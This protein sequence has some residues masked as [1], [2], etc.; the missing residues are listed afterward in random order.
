MIQAIKDKLDYKE[1]REDIREFREN[2]TC[3]VPHGIAVI[4]GILGCQVGQVKPNLKQIHPQHFLNSHG[5][6]TT[7]PL[8][9]AGLDNIYPFIP[10]NDLV[11]DFQKFLSL[12]FLPAAVVFHIGKCFLLHCLAPPLL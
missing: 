4:Y 10:R 11:H 5:R 8:G 3:E 1:V 2:N 6:T 12:G 9:I 7:L